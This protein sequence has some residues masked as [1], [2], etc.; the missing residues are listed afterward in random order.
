MYEYCQVC[1]SAIYTNEGRGTEANGQYSR[2]FCSDCYRNGHFTSTAQFTGDGQL[3]HGWYYNESP[4]ALATPYYPGM[5][6][7]MG[8]NLH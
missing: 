7:Y 4:M 5:Y 3:N 1:G 8:Y 6:G 2:D